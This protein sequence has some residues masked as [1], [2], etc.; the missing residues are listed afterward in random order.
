M[1]SK[2]LRTLIKKT[3][4]FKTLAFNLL[5]GLESIE[6]SRKTK[7]SKSCLSL[8]AYFGFLP[9][10]FRLDIIYCLPERA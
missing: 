8:P 5:I 3:F 1:K 6:T 4:Q 7:P 2:V 10:F 9:F